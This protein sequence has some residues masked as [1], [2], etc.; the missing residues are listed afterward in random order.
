M[1]QIECLDCDGSGLIEGQEWNDEK[2]R[3]CHGTGWVVVDDDWEYDERYDEQPQ[4][5][6]QS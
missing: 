6:G 5:R 2:C 3:T 1:T 4:I